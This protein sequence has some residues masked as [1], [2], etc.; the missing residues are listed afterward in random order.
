MVFGKKN[1]FV[2]K[3]MLRKIIEFIKNISLM[4][5]KNKSVSFPDGEL[6]IDGESIGKVKNISFIPCLKSET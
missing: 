6:L 3:I 1:F 2:R 5:K 4:S